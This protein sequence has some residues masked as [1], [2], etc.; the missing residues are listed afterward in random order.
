MVTQTP[1]QFS[2]AGGE[3]TTYGGFTFSGGNWVP[4]TQPQ[5]P[6][7]SATTNP[8]DNSNA[9]GPNQLI[10][11]GSRPSQ[12]FGQNSRDL[13]QMIA[14]NGVTPT[15]MQEPGQEQ[16]DMFK[17]MET[18][19][20]PYTQM[21][22]KISA[23]SDKATQNLIAT[24]KAKKANSMRTINDETDRLKQGLLSLGLSTGNINFTPDLVYGQVAQAEN[25][26]MS[27][28]QQ[29]DTD[30]ATALL[31]AQ[32]AVDEKDFK[33]L[34]EKMDYIKTIKKSRLD[35]LKENSDILSYENKIGEQQATRIYDELQKM[36]ES[37]KLQFLQQVATQFNIPL[38][39]LTS[40][41]NEITRG[42]QKSSSSSGGYTSQ[43]LRKLRQAGID[44]SDIA[45]ADDFLY[46]EGD[47][48]AVNMTSILGSLNKAYANPN[49]VRN[50]KFTYEYIK[51]V[52]NNLPP[53]VDRTDFIKKIKSKLSIP[54]WNGAKQYGLTKN[55]YDTLI[56]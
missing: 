36:P 49:L 39:A 25:A 48:S 33:L 19:S 40:Q 15:S 23:K 51:N 8:N 30:E 10:V 3:G 47:D 1:P 13:N 21:L 42:R 50:G 32:Q 26:R 9:F 52:L 56:K 24:I 7:Q 16:K 41:V 37:S 34:K 27:K 44:S 18:Y 2:P 46:G 29:L 31:E 17:F 5:T 54:N 43:E 35:T 38:T 11:T 6:P 14:M 4:T 45:A 55:E 12:Q 53:S 20:D 28:L 22:D